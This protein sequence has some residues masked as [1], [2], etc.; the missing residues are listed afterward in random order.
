MPTHFRVRALA[1]AAMRLSRRA[2]LL[3]AGAVP[4]CAGA[5]EPVR[6]VCPLA[7]APTVLIPG[8]SDS[9]ATRLLGSKLYRGLCRF[10]AH[11][12]AQPDL[13]AGWDIAADGLTYVFHL[14]PDL[15]W[16]D[17]GALTADDVVFSI[18]RFHRQLQPRLGLER[19]IAAQA[20]DPQT[21]VF[22]LAA[23][24]EPFLRQLDALSAPI[25][26]KHV[27]DRPGFALDDPQV[28]PV[29]AGPFWMVE[30]SRMTRFEWFVGDRPAVRDI[31]IPIVADLAARAAL[32][33]QPGVL[34]VGGAVDL[35]GLRSLQQGTA[36]AVGS[37]PAGAIAG[38]RL[39]HAVTP[40]DDVRV[41]LGLASAIDRAM[42][43]RDV[44]FGLGKIATGPGVSGSQD[45]DPT[46]MLPA[47]DPLAASASFT[48]AGLRPDD[49]GIRLR[50]SHLVP[51]GEPWQRLATRLQVML[52]YVGVELAPE[53]VTAAE[54]TRRVAAGAY[55]TTG[56]LER[57]TG[58]LTL[59][60][61]RYAADVP[62]LTPLLDGDARAGALAAAQTML[63]RAAPA[64]W[65]VEPAVP[66]VRD[67]RL[68]LPGGVFSNFADARLS[69][70]LDSVKP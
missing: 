51:P 26:P 50:L 2:L 48:A 69:P 10:D 11:G 36:L 55:E 58:D 63:V 64:L 15:I 59:D 12:V 24:F 70:T 4:V 32:L 37:E 25:V 29:G 6:I 39:N 57:Q 8:L 66:V 21:A 16:H 9:L 53:P 54:W 65:L 7:A 14:R 44:W 28:M 30:R 41:R 22:T 34:L 62:A 68:S 1:Y 3:A 46:A 35:A 43:L 42:V 27:H 23:P 18:T 52:G 38:L 47:Y 13:A 33:D 60:F 40:L 45:R 20:A 56:F 49:D 17:S 61:A 31:D 67:R 5:A 19:V